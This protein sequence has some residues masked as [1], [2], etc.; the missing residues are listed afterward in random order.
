MT[1]EEQQHT[2]SQTRIDALRTGYRFIRQ[3]KHIWIPE[4][5]AQAQRRTHQDSI[6]DKLDLLSCSG[7]AFESSVSSLP[8]PQ[9]S[10]VG[11][12]DD[13]AALETSPR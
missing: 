11:S 12:G 6:A 7:E 10:D 1:D 2:N 8:G 9:Y 5:H 4:D 13:H 3:C